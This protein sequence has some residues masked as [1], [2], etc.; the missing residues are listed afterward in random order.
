MFEMT[1]ELPLGFGNTLVARLLFDRALLGSPGY[2]ARIER[3]IAG[4]LAALD[5]LALAGRVWNNA[6]GPVD[7]SADEPR[8][9]EN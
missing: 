1:V 8:S 9:Q 2:A 7:R 3:D 6:G 5:Q 4:S